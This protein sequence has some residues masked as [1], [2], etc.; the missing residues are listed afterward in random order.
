MD[1]DQLRKLLQARRVA[2]TGDLLPLARRLALES[3]A[4]PL[5]TL[6]NPPFF[7]A[8]ENPLL[9]GGSQ[10]GKLKVEGLIIHLEQR[11]KRLIATTHPLVGFGDGLAEILGD[12][13][14]FWNDNDVIGRAEVRG[15]SLKPTD[16]R[17]FAD[18]GRPIEHDNNRLAIDRCGQPSRQLGALR[19]SPDDLDCH[20]DLHL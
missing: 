10:F 18:S 7:G 4:V 16:Q 13:A 12:I 17:G 9:T 14:A 3:A 1:A 5:D 8:L 15:L 6:P 20:L 11:I 2:P 19:D